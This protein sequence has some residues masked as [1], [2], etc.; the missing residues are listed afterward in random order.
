MHTNRATFYCCL[1]CLLLQ[2]DTLEIGTNQKVNT[3][4]SQQETAGP[5]NDNMQFLKLEGT[6]T[7]EFSDNEV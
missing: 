4:R 2:T 1:I 3:K 5:R 7:Q 6:K